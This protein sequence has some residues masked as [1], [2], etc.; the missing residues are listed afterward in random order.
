[1]SRHALGRRD[2]NERI[3]IQA[4]RAAGAS[5]HQ[6][7]GRDTPDLVVGYGGRNYMM[8]VKSAR[9]RPSQGQRAFSDNWRGQV[10]VVQSP[11][12]AIAIILGDL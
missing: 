7:T 3:I 9:R 10:C 1:M 12:Q 2:Q 4:L 8:E 5:V 6:L 11:E